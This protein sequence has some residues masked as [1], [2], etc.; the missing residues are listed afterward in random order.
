MTRRR[1]FTSLFLAFALGACATAPSTPAANTVATSPA[2]ATSITLFEG[3]CYYYASCTTY[4]ITVRPDG[5]YR[6]DG[7]S[8]TRAEGV[9]EGN[10][11]PEA[12]AAAEAALAAA[13][14]SALPERMNG[15]DTNV[16][17]PEVYPCMNHAPG[18][19][20]TRRTTDGQEKQVFWDMGCRSSRMDVLLAQMRQAF[21]YDELVAP[22]S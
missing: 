8:L 1:A 9:S 21:R 3:G 19:R 5:S 14:F 2:E 13:N 17:R 16:W 18:M 22:A 12:F 11:G 10:L 6:L 4:E 15:S 7:Q 20:I